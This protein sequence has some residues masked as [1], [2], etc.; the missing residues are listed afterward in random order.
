M[1]PID[2]W[3][4]FVRTD[5]FD[6]D[7]ADNGLDD[8]DMARLENVLVHDPKAGDVI[9]GTGGLRKLRFAREGEG[10]SGSLRVC[11]AFFPDHGIVLL[12]LVYGKTEKKDLTPAEKAYI[13]HLL[14]QFREQLDAE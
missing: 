11:Y 5:T 1:P 4:Q 8:E 14:E 10:K 2:E 12:P 7:W 9:A 3:W 6:E 13:K